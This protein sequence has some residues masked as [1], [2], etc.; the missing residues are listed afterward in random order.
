MPDLT[1]EDAAAQPK[2]DQH[3]TVLITGG[4]GRIGRYLKDRLRR[5]GRTLRLLDVTPPERQAEDA[6]G[7]HGIE[8]VVASVTDYPAVHAAM[9]GVDAVV[10]L[11]GIA[12]TKAPASDLTHVNITGT[13][14]VFEAA[15]LHGVRRI[16]FASSNHAAGFGERTI[17]GEAGLPRPDSFYGVTKVFGEA[18]GSLYHDRD[19]MDVVCLRI[20][21]CKD[22]PTD[23]RSLGTWLSPDDAGRLVEAALRHPSPGF[24]V[25]WGVSDNRRRPRAWTLDAARALGFRPEDDGEAFADQIEER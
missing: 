24:V 8:H 4:A 5:P 12:S 25:V 14:H 15:R 16:V 2:A 3:Q 23:L 13:T 18:L 22:Q 20:G 11:A 10:H 19:G 17:T 1:P 7:A 9:E 21:T 6:D